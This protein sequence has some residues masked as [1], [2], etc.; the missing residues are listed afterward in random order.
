M[1]QK[2]RR[3]VVDG[4]VS[5]TDRRGFMKSAAAAGVGLM[6]GRDSSAGTVEVRQQTKYHG[7]V[8][9]Q[10]YDKNLDLHSGPCDR[11]A[12]LAGGCRG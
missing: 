8:S 1:M 9:L 2:Q 10:D 3:S 12:R 4:V 6:A 7:Y 11:Q 5:P